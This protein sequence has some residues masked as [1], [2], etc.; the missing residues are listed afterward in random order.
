MHKFIALFDLHYG[1]ERKNGHVRNIHELGALEGVLKF[2]KDFKPQ[3][4]ILGGDFMDCGPVS[5][6]LDGKAG[7]LEGLRLMRDYEGARKE[8]VLP[9][10]SLGAKRLVYHIGNH[11]DWIGQ[12]MERIP[13][14]EGML[15]V[16]KG[17]QLG[18]EWEVIPQGG[19]SRIGK[20]HFMHGDTIRSKANPAKVA[21]ETYERSI[22]FG[23][24]HKFSAF[25]KVS[26][27]DLRD[28]RT[29]VGVPGLCRRDPFYGK[30][31]P[32][33]HALGFLWGYVNEDGTFN[34]YVTFI[35]KN[36]FIA[37]GKEYKV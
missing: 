2:A 25:T 9:L 12:L 7:A 21:V 22:R 23:H 26:A 11:E 35:S 27:L 1:K 29:G 13:A 34:D 18:R 36:R 32:N 24:F 3:T 28:V 5:H 30:G 10:E 33:G 37:E 19:V 8:V 31:A 4:V 20:L 17:L 16:Q 14:L 15:D 6:H